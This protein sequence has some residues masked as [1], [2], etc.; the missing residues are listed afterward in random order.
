MFVLRNLASLLERPKALQDRVFKKLFRQA[1]IAQYNE[2]ERRQYQ[3]SLKE[4]WDYTSTLDTAY[5]KG[6]RKGR[7]K[8]REEGLIEGREEG[9]IEGREEGQQKEKVETVHR[10]QQMGLTMEQ[11]AQGVGITIEEVAAL[12]S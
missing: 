12:L 7:E 2:E 9:L 5:M 1:E 3:A 11:I 4:Y 6:E 10:L 8:G